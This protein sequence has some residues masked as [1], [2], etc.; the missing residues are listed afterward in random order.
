MGAKVPADIAQ[1][2]APGVAHLQQCRDAVNA[3]IGRCARMPPKFSADGAPLTCPPTLHYLRNRSKATLIPCETA[4]D[5]EC[6]A[7]R[8]LLF[9]LPPVPQPSKTHNDLLLS[10]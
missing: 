1:G 8:P 9:H 4:R 6:N 2:K 3:E 5:C 7:A 10:L